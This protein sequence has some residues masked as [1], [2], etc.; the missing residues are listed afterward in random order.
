MG[1]IP[2]IAASRI[3]QFAEILDEAGAPVD[4]YLEASGIPVGIREEVVGIMEF[5]SEEAAEPK[6]ELLEIMAHVGAQL[7]RVIER[8]RAE[9]E[10][11]HSRQQLLNLYNRVA[12]KE[13]FLYAAMMLLS[14]S[15][16][17]GG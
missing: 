13:S 17:V 3:A 6:D 8:Q 4:Q 14:E 16:E 9:Q 12:G 15:L 7:G 11:L 1:S 10:D 2:I 5:F